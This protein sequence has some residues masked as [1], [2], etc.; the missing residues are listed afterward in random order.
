MI[1]VFFL[2]LDAAAQVRADGK[3]RPFSPGENV[4][5][6]LDW[7]PPWYLFFLP[8]MS[9]GEAEVTLSD[10]AE[11]MDRKALKI[12]FSARSSGTFA[13]LVGM[14]VDD[15]WEMLTDPDTFCTFRTFK[16]EREGK[17]KRD[18]EV[19]YLPQTRQL[20]IR[21]LDLAISPPKVRRDEDRN[22]IPECVH[23]LFSAVYATRLRDF[24]PGAKYRSILGDND[25][26]KD[27]EIRV[28]KSENVQTPAGA[29][30]A[31]RVDTVAIVGGLFKQGGQLRVWLTADEKKVPV[32]LEVKVPL[33]TVV[34]KLKSVRY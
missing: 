31:W 33:G 10:G 9:A 23:D 24:F 11:Y 1:C 15:K 16:Q 3:A 18:I 22:D 28:D 2:V 32:Q 6:D 13:K 21:E 17:R 4:V 26:I 29:F 30:K 27:I 8:Q 12:T 19:I 25:K 14:K 20:H 5:F 34:G 7:K